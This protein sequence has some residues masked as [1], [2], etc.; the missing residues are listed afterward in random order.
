MER[1]HNKKHRN[2]K[3][4]FTTPPYNEQFRDRDVMHLFPS[5]GL[6]YLISNT[7]KFFPGIETTYFE[8]N[9]FLKNYVETILKM[10][11]DIIAISVSFFNSQEAI[12]AINDIKRHM[13]KTFIIVGG[14]YATSSPEIIL[15]KSNADV[16]VI[17][18]G[19]KT[20]IELLKFIRGEIKKQDSI[21][22]IAF[23]KRNKIIITPKR[24]LETNLDK[25]PFPYWDAINIKDYPDYFYHKK[26]PEMI[27]ISSRGCP[28]NCNFCSNPVWK[29]STPLKRFRSSK[30]I[31]EEIRTLVRK[32]GVKEIFDYSDEFNIDLKWA[33]SVCRGIEQLKFED[34]SFKCMLHASNVTEELASSLKKMGTWFVH[35]G[36]ESGNQTTLDGIGKNLTIKGIVNACKILKRHK[37]KVG[38]FFILYHIWEKDNKLFYETT[39]DVENT[40]D[41]AKYL[42][43]KGLLDYISWGF[44]IPTP[45][46]RVY[47]TCKKFHL[48]TNKNLEEYHNDDMVFSLPDVK[49][50][51]MKKIKFKG[52][53]LEGLNAVKKGNVNLKQLK[54]IFQKVLTMMKY[55][56][57]SSLAK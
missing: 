54:Y 25:Y 22:G 46:S 24:D 53:M 21:K 11:P 23:R 4:L 38:G 5:L 12:R 51:E 18:E 49:E 39:K 7:K 48:L 34:I 50:A 33:Y 36:V 19:E 57:E 52:M 32:Y 37:I 56:I 10:S 45:G 15:K 55:A 27:F 1:I 44:L 16:C 3:I 41:F 30:N 43:K 14:P 2:L 17:G 13:K 31:K 8:G 29:V 26:T 9:C 28:F 20:F 40:L 6:L 42:L 35:I 47:E